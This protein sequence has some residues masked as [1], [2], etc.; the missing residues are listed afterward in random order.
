MDAGSSVAVAVAVVVVAVVVGIGVVAAG[1]I[2]MCGSPDYC[3][4]AKS[5]KRHM[6]AMGSGG[7]W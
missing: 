4:E 5:S 1:A 6:N 3:L 7:Q 2:A